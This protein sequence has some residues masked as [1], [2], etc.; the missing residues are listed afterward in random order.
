MLGQGQHLHRHRHGGRLDHRL[1][2]TGGLFRV[3]HQRRAVPV[4]DHLAHRAAH[5]DINEVCAGGLRGN[6]RGLGHAGF[7]AAEDLRGEGMLAGKRRE[8]RAAFFV[9][10]AQRFRTYQLGAGQARAVLGADLAEGRV[11]H[12]SHGASASFD[13][14]VT[15]PICTAVA[16]FLVHSF[17]IISQP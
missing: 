4:V 15:V 13:S 8:Q 5:I 14:I 1:G 3:A 7:V 17:I 12:A 10:I 11:R 9:L 16:S 2:D 6:L